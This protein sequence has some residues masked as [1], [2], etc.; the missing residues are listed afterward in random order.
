MI[1][2]VTLLLGLVMGERAVEV[3][4]S[5]EGTFVLLEYAVGQLHHL[6]ASL[7]FEALGIPNG[8]ELGR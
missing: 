1:E 8:V 7:A 3:A 6:E 2:F 5:R 4:T